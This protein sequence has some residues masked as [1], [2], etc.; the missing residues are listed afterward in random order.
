MAQELDVIVIGGGVAGLGCA[1]LLGPSLRVAVLERED[2]VGRHSTGRSAA[3]LIDGYGNAAIRAL[4]ALGRGFYAD[5]DPA[6]WPAPLLAPRGELLLARAGEADLL[7]R[8][9][10]EIGG[11]E[12]LTPLQAQALVPVLRPAALAGAAYDPRA[13]DIDVDLLVQGYARLLRSHGGRIETGAGAQ[14]LARAGGVWRV[15]TPKGGFA[16]PVVVNAAGAWGDEVGAMAGAAPVGLRPLRRSAAILPAPGGA[17]VTR[18]PMF[19]ALAE[20]WYAK[21]TG[22]KLMVS[23][24]DEDPVAPQDA[25][26][27]DMTLAEGLDRYAAM[28]TA[29]VT[30]VERAWA[31]LRSFVAD[32][33]PVAGFDPQ[34]EGFFWLVGQGGYGVQTAPA[35]SRL[36]ADLI[37]GRAP[38]APPDLRAALAPARLRAAA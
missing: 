3:M 36:A 29:P 12:A 10:G 25:W 8:R 22:G 7:A 27:D 23:P 18:W 28:V 21:P 34:A 17:D 13:M 1:A 5:P 33:T 15:D 11:L 31:G 14:A 38:A 30:R 4:T 35:L 9:L 2:A 37:A 16:A 26:P 32:R 6:F 20:D 24:A 19:G